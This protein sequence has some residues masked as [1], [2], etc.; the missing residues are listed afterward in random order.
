ME[1][2]KRRE[3]MRERQGSYHKSL[4]LV[5]KVEC[6]CLDR[7]VEPV[8]SAPPKKAKRRIAWGE[9]INSGYNPFVYCWIDLITNKI[10]VK[11][12]W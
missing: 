12:L 1:V 3:R 10:K 4:G 7:T 9:D 6:V 5:S 2:V 8:S 11:K